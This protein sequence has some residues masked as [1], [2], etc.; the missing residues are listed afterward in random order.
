M[1]KI[2]PHEKELIEQFVVEGLIK[3]Y[4]NDDLILLL[5]KDYPH[6]EEEEFRRGIRAANAI[7][8]EEVLTDLDKVIPQHI[9]IYEKIYQEFDTLY[10]LPGKLK[11]MRQKERLVGLHKEQ[12]TIEVINEVNIEVES[13]SDYDLNKLTIV[14][15]KRLGE[16]MKR[17][18]NK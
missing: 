10:Y 6:L 1:K 13:G 15:Q 8:K 2:L 18:M 7:I 12:N 14:E 11:A 4:S 3:G 9:E 16:L 5:K 17:I